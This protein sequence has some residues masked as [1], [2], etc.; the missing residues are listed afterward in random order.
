MFFATAQQLVIGIFRKEQR[1][2]PPTGQPKKDTMEHS[3]RVCLHDLRHERRGLAFGTPGLPRT[4]RDSPTGG[5]PIWSPALL[6]LQRKLRL[7]SMNPD[8]SYLL[9]QP[10]P[11][12][13]WTEVKAGNQYTPRG[14]ELVWTTDGNEVRKGRFILDDEKLLNRPVDAPD[15][16]RIPGQWIDESGCQIASV[17][18]GPSSP[19]EFPA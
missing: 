16:W 15:W 10:E 19:P 6:T 3:R 4:D 13:D 17:G 7:F 1:R 5:I 18:H 2:R 9:T 14:N 8:A 12:P 11:D